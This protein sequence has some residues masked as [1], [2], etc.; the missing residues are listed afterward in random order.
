MLN[1]YIDLIEDSE[2]KN[3]VNR[4]IHRDECIACLRRS[5]SSTGD[6]HPADEFS[7]WGQLLHTLRVTNLAVQIYRSVEYNRLDMDIII[8]GAL[9]H[10]VPY[11]FMLESGYCNMTHAVD[12]GLWFLDNTILCGYKK[13]SIAT[14]IINHMG[15]WETSQS[16]IL[17]T[18]PMTSQA[19]AVH[20]ADSISS[21]KNINVDIQDINYLRNKIS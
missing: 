12:N 17:N 18:Y 6:F 5:S 16:A 14:C 9:L 7:E 4:L 3:E 10:D 13:E 15:K 2:I 19:W 8:A 11:K 1:K 21:C 20:L